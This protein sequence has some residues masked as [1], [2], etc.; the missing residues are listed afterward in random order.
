M[1]EN[2]KVARERETIGK[3]LGDLCAEVDRVAEEIGKLAELL[4]PVL[5]PAPSETEEKRLATESSSP[6]GEKLLE[7][8]RKVRH[9]SSR[10]VAIQEQLE[11]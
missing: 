7:L 1:D 5:V 10:L 9:Q 2:C 8:Q 3:Q 4:A 6:I 11:L